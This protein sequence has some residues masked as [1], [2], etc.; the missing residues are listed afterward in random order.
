MQLTTA[1]K[2]LVAVR[3]K[4]AEGPSPMEQYRSAKVPAVRRQALND[5]LNFGVRGVGLGAAFRGLHGL[6]GMF[7]DGTDFNPVPAGTVEMPVVLP[8]NAI[9]EEEEKQ[10]FES[11]QPTSPEGLSMYM[12]GM[13]L[14]GGLGMYGGWKGVDML[15]DNQRKKKTQEELDDAKATYSAA[16]RNMYKKSSAEP[17]LG[18]QLGHQ[19]DKLYDLMQ[20]SA[21]VLDWVK[22]QA[23]NMNSA[24][25]DTFPNAKGMGTGAALAYSIPTAAAGYHIVNSVMD[26]TS[27]RKLLDK[28]MQERARR[29]NAMRPSELYA[30]PVTED[31]INEVG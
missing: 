31:E 29:Q 12:P 22:T 26:K 30:V 15:I 9:E 8:N 20:K 1:E 4:K 17:S 28:A 10:A 6:S 7:N 18:E 2:L 14:A 19:L 23:G 13:M 5:I 3:E 24:F 27:K 21:G 25:D 11:T 16:M